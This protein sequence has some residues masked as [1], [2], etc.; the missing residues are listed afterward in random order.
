MSKMFPGRRTATGDLGLGAGLGL[1]VE[2]IAF[3]LPCYLFLEIPG[4]DDDTHS[5]IFF[6]A[7]RMY[8]FIV[9]SSYNQIVG[10]WD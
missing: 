7:L 6:S 4:G 5:P 2:H 3:N 9:H 1:G 10:A 8:L